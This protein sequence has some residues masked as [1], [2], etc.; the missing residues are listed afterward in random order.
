MIRSACALHVAV[1]VLLLSVCCF[2]ADAATYKSPDGKIIL[3]ASTID[4]TQS[5]LAAKGK[6]HIEVAKAVAA[7]SFN[8]SA[9]A[10]TVML[11]TD[12]D[13]K[14]K[15]VGLDAIKS[16]QMTGFVEVIYVRTEAD[17]VVKTTSSAQEAVYDGAEQIVKL[18][19]QVKVTHHD[20][21]MFTQP[22]V[23]TGD[24]ATV[25]VKSDLGP[26]DFRFRIE[27]S[28]GVSRIEVSPKEKAE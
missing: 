15:R 23:L 1:T 14:K 8:A 11:F 16:A 13:Q 5:R 9:D 10:I 24:K 7:T 18:S 26:E 27:S 12:T 4:I 19:G 3:S 28:P 21:N 25:N 20:P 2:A 17:A 22:A 6:A